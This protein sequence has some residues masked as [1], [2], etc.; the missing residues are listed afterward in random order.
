MLCPFL[1]IHTPWIFCICNYEVSCSAWFGRI[2]SLYL[3]SLLNL[4]L[5]LSIWRFP[6]LQGYLAFCKFFYSPFSVSSN[7]W[8][9]TVQQRFYWP[10]EEHFYLKIFVPLIPIHLVTDWILSL[11]YRF[12]LTKNKSHIF[13]KLVEW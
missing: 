11:F 3:S 10:L 4:S 6:S 1:K 2:I 8:K 7:Y 5:Y 12:I 9:N 13:R